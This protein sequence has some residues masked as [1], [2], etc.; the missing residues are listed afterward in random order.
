[1]SRSPAKG[2]PIAEQVRP[3]RVLAEYGVALSR[4]AT[5]I[6]TGA[7][8]V[9]KELPAGEARTL[10]PADPKRSVW[11]R[12]VLPAQIEVDR[13]MIRTL[14]PYVAGETFDASVREITHHTRAHPRDRAGRAPG[15]G[16]AAR[17]RIHTR[18]GQAIERHRGPGRSGMARGSR[19]DRSDDRRAKPATSRV[20]K[21]AERLDGRRSVPLPRT[22]RRPGRAD[23]RSLRPVLG[24]CPPVREPDRTP[25][26]RSS[27]HRRAPPCACHRSLIEHPSSGR[28]GA[29]RARRRRRATAAEG[30]SRSLR[31]GRGGAGGSPR[32]RAQRRPWRSQPP[33][34]DRARGQTDDAHGT[35][36]RGTGR[37]DRQDRRGDR[38]SRPRAGV[39]R[40]TRSPIRRWEVTDPR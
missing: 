4:L 7:T 26:A 15:P 11:T 31:H 32:D 10:P 34:R 27:G 38:R 23:R 24:R 17:A 29:T 6:S 33:A 36:P 22:G 25:V 35:G 37:R 12:L 20:R 21:A 14:R 9:I 2:L 16:H 39:A 3:G 19:T 30:P 13:G 5:E 8:V 40:P 18:G 1:M 28:R